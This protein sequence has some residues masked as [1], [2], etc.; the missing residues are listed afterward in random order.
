MVFSQNPP[1]PSWYLWKEKNKAVS[2]V[3]RPSRKRFGSETIEHFSVVYSSSPLG[4][5]IHV[6][7]TTPVV[8]A[9]KNYY[10]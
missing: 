5:F 9:L 4:C 10:I 1:S 2:E 8:P 7:I 6:S 3:K